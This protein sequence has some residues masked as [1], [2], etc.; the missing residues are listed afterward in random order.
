MTN[1]TTLQT[2]S[3]KRYARM[4][5]ETLTELTFL[6]DRVSNTLGTIAPVIELAKDKDATEKKRLLRAV[7]DLAFR[8]RR[9][10]RA[11]SQ[12]WALVLEENEEPL[13]SP[14]AEDFADIFQTAK[15]I[16]I[17]DPPP[18]S[19]GKSEA[20][21]ALCEVVGTDPPPNPSSVIA[22]AVPDLG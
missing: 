7:V 11:F 14:Y 1:A 4:D 2:V 17:P 8:G 3:R 15:Q 6:L 16:T 12:Q 22:E 5:K 13:L 10:L 19:V 9:A 21:H 18:G 20:A